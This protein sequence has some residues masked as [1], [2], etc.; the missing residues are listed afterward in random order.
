VAARN[1]PGC[2]REERKTRDD[3]GQHG[4]DLEDH[5]TVS[6]RVEVAWALTSM[7][8]P[9]AAGAANPVTS[10]VTKSNVVDIRPAGNYFSR[11]RVLRTPGRA[12]VR[13]VSL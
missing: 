6:L 13:G 9:Q 7:T 1:R 3:D 10:S 4:E 8:L 12:I 2:K 11:R 5:E